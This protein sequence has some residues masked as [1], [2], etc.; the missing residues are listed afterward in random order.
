MPGGSTN[1]RNFQTTGLDTRKI[2]NIFAIVIVLLIFIFLG[3][4]VWRYAQRSSRTI[5]DRGGEITGTSE[6][7]KY[8]ASEEAKVLQLPHQVCTPNLL[9][10]EQ[11]NR[12][13]S[14]YKQRGEACAMGLIA[15][16]PTKLLR[17]GGYCF[18]GCS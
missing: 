10:K 6:M 7:D 9:N 4:A 12:F 18:K 17:K 2:G 14:I 1:T 11:R 3:I 13:D 5:E 16:K 8:M 15:R